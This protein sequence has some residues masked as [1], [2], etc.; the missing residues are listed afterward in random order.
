MGRNRGEG[1]VEVLIRKVGR[2]VPVTHRVSSTGGGE[3]FPP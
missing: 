2:S 1:V 3:S